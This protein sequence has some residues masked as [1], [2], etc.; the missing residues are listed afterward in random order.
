YGSHHTI[1]FL[2]H[3]EDYSIIPFGPAL[4]SMHFV[5]SIHAGGFQSLKNCQRR[6]VD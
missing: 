6:A 5:Q 3:T 2:K 1:E 4:N